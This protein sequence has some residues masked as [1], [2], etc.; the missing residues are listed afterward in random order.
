VTGSWRCWPSPGA[1]LAAGFFCPLPRLKRFTNADMV[2]M[3]DFFF[4]ISFDYIDD[5]RYQLSV[6]RL[7]TTR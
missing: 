3:G 1:V 7:T 6:V 5:K 2:G 4:F